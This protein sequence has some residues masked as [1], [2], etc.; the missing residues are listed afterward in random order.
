MDLRAAARPDGKVQPKCVIQNETEPFEGKQTS[1]DLAA[2]LNDLA[3][4]CV[5]ANS[6]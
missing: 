6:Y 5:C 3:R 2:R 4:A 1:A